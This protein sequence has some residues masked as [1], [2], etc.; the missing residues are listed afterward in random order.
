MADILDEEL[1]PC[2]SCWELKT[3][4]CFYLG[5]VG[6]RRTVCIECMRKCENER[7][8]KRYAEMKLDPHFRRIR[9]EANARYKKRKRRDEK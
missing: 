4:E 3:G 2:T 8:Q 7:S 1:R 9:R 6:R 5:R